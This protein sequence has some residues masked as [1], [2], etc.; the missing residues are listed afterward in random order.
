MP[1]PS[2]KY[3]HLDNSLH[4]HLQLGQEVPKLR[5]LLPASNRDV[6]LCKTLLSAN[7]LGYATPTLL[8]WEDVFDTKSLLGGGSHIAKVSKVLKYLQSLPQ[9][10]DDDLVLMMD[11]FDIWLQLRPE[12]MIARYMA[13]NRAAN[14]RIIQH[15]GDAAKAENISQT[16][17]FGAGK[18]CAPNQVHT[19][20]CYPIPVSPIPDDIYGQNT[21]TVMGR[22]KV[23]SSRQRFLNSGYIIGPARDMRRMF[24]RAWEKIEHWPKHH[25]EDNGSHESDNMYSGSDQAVFAVMFGEQEIQRERIHRRH[26]PDWATKLGQGSSKAANT[27]EGTEVGSDILNPPFTHETMPEEPGKSF[28]FGMGLDYFSDLGHQTVNSE[29]DGRFMQYDKP[30]EEF[31]KHANDGRGMFDCTYRGEARLPQDV[32]ESA[33]PLADLPGAMSTN[34]EWSNLKLYTHLCM[35]R[36][37]VMVHHNGNKDARRSL[38]PE[39]WFQRHGHTFVET[40]LRDPKDSD[41]DMRLGAYTDNAGFLDWNNLCPP[42][43]SAELFR[44]E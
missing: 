5:I 9:E 27:I 37:P 29:W 11:A 31:R 10:A 36:V 18:K 25:P 26:T 32:L 19:L 22:N 12:T 28:E 23:S 3:Q 42:E 2:Q 13:I 21:D 38:W 7:I 15:M 44:T 41:S 43:Y 4:D 34:Q 33:S 40:K 17:V 14:E 35:D 39:V 6:N 24:E 30:A 8:A 1:L 16:V 20:A